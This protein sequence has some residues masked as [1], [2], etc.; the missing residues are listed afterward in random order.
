MTR[1][2]TRLLTSTTL[3]WLCATVLW[4]AH[5]PLQAASG[6]VGKAHA[7]TA[8]D[9]GAEW[10][11][12]TPAQRKVLA[13]LAPHWR[14]I[15]GTGREK[16]INVANRFDRLSP[17]ERERMQERMDQWARLPA[18]QRGEARLRFQ[19]TRQISADER[20]KKW[21]AYQ[22][23]SP[24]DRQDLTRQAE[25]KAKP[26]FLPNDMSGPREAR[27]AYAVKRPV[28]P[29]SPSQKSNLVPNAVPGMATSRTV[30]R[31]AL[32]KA[33]QGA[34]TN[35]VNQRPAPPLHQ[36][37]GLPKIAAT[38]GF[39]DPVTL[40]PRKGAQGAAM[41]PPPLDPA[42]KAPPGR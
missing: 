26:V 30:V 36:Q 19:Q 16:W 40:L 4:M 24:E 18:Q 5:G 21:A 2:Q 32:V 14:K 34:T 37:A 8:V 41:T 10:N 15:D 25:R 22:A 28:A 38:T 12:L 9:D 1:S 23:L 17:A 7:G 6:V 20:Q 13:P 27:Q 29:N 11:E 42:R 3:A 33:G 35:L 39:V 31:P